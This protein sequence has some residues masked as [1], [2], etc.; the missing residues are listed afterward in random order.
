ML[1]LSISHG[2]LEDPL[3]IAHLKVI[4]QEWLLILPK[5]EYRCSQIHDTPYKEMMRLI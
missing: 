4:N 1:A 2:D 5:Y 3:C